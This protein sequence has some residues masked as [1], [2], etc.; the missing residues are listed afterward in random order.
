[1]RDAGRLGDVPGSDPDATLT[2]SAV[3]PGAAPPV[4]ITSGEQVEVVRGGELV[5][6][7]NHG[8]D[9]GE[10]QLDGTDVLTGAAA[11]GLMLPQHGV[12]IVKR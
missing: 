10:L 4:P 12:A 5:F 11:A 8:P 3:S 7:I 1:M 2:G 6:A 9:A